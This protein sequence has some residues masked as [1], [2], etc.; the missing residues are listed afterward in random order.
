MC[1]GHLGIGDGDICSDGD[2]QGNGNGD[3]GNYYGDFGNSDRG[4]PT[5][6]HPI[7]ISCLCFLLLMMM[8][9]MT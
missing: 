3:P 2:D 1:D 6:W 8:M 4:T 5:K 7:I 9:M